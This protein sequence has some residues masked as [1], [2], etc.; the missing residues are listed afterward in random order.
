M[1]KIKYYRQQAGLTQL[2]FAKKMQ[3]VQGTASQWE[4]GK[5]APSLDMIIKIAEV[6]NVSPTLLLDIE[7][8]QDTTVSPTKIPPEYHRIPIV[9]SV[10]CSWEEGFIQDFDGEYT[11][12]NEHLYDKYGD[13]VRATVARGNSMKDMINPGDLLIVVPAADVEND[14][15]VIATIGDDELTAK[16]FHY[17][18]SGGFDLIPVNPSYGRQSFTQQEIEMLPVNVVGRVIEIRKGLRA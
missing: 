18:A 3:V 10:A 4:S 12:I 7:T 14:D 2:E 15:I 5:R 11:F 1:N 17:N 13:M 16:Q 6:L 9:G 8:P